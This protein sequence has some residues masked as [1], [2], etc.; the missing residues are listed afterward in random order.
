MTSR[1]IVGAVTTLTAALE[2]ANIEYAVSGA[3][4][5]GYWVA[6]RATLDVDIALNLPA[7]ALPHLFETLKEAGCELRTDAAIG[8][9]LGDFGGRYGG[10]RFDFFLPVLPI[11][12]DALSR[13]VRVPFAAG[14]IWILSAEDLVVFKLKFGRTKDFTD[15]ERPL[16]AQRGRLAWGYLDQQ[17]GRIFDP[18]DPRILRLEELKNLSE[19]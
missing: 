15:I 7:A 13:R 11:S 18:G 19:S 4:A 8:A 12:I 1:D 14:E 2:N 6:P 10:I 5:L 9:Q 16:A 17:V 3:I